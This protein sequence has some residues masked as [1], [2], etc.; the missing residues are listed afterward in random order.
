LFIDQGGIM[1]KPAAYLFAILVGAI[2]WFF[3]QHFKIEGMKEVRVVPKS[4]D[5]INRVT[6]RSLGEG[7]AE[8]PPNESIFDRFRLPRP[9]STAKSST[10]DETASDGRVQLKPTNLDEPKQRQGTLRIASFHLSFF[11]ATMSDKTHVMDI[12]ARVVRRY[13]VIALQGVSPGATTAV[14][15]L[16]DLANQTGRK[17]DYIVAPPAEVQHLDM[18][19]AYV[20][21]SQTIM[22]DRGELYSLGD[23]QD[24]LRREPLVGWF[25]ARQASASTAFTFTLVNVHTEQLRLQQELNVLDDVLYEVRDDGREEDD[26]IMLGCFNA[27]DRQ[28]GEL[29]AVPNLVATVRGVP[30]TIDQTGQ[31]ENIVFQSTSTDEFMGATGVFDFLRA[32]NLSRERALEVSDYMPV[33][34]EFSIH[35]GGERGRVATNPV[36]QR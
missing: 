36:G 17:Y 1:R 35:E 22:C 13:D 29:G 31:T 12:V 25:R 19:Y 27:D 9:F 10:N 11:G 8:D 6:Q 3:F 24:L 14:A 7:S 23:P 30:T 32:Y 34:A 5:E 18:Q 2:I 16:V 15:E 26:V 21:D 20:F 28:L 33:W 4:E